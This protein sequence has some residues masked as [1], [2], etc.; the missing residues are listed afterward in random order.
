M[1]V[2]LEA[3]AQARDHRAQSEADFRAALHRAAEHHSMRQI[4]VHAG[5]SY[6]GV[7]WLLKEAEENQ[8]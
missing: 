2:Y 5:L 1:S 6:S 4:A 8:R 3:V 7:R